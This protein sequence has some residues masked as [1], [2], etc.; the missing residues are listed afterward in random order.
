[1]AAPWASLASQQ[2]TP[3]ELQK[4]LQ[5]AACFRSDSQAPDPH[6]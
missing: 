4:E 5:V 3:E 1:M 6:S 2:K